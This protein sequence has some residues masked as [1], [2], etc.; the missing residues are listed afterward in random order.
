MAQQNQINPATQP[1]AA[2]ASILNSILRKPFREPSIA[3]RWT[4]SDAQSIINPQT[5]TLE[6]DH[7]FEIQHIVDKLFSGG[8]LSEDK[9]SPQ[10]VYNRPLGHFVWLAV[11]IS[12]GRNICRIDK[13]FNAEKKTYRYQD[14]LPGSRLPKIQAYLDAKIVNDNH[15]K[16]TYVG[17][18][19]ADLAACMAM[20]DPKDT[21]H[22]L[23][24]Y[25]GLQIC[26]DFEADGWYTKW[27]QAAEGK[28]VS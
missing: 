6:R 9:N 5:T 27:V 23:V 1:R 15:T 16:E 17:R 14:F 8:V 2:C 19:L 11:Y 28:M 12:D 7:F 10:Y 18:N 13:S 3:E 20:Y 26:K 4:V 22:E 25:I 24:R 21:E